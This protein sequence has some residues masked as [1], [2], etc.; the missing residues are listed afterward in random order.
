LVGTSSQPGNGFPSGH[1]F[2]REN[3]PAIARVKSP[4]KPSAVNASAAG[5]AFDTVGEI[6]ELFESQLFSG[7]QSII[8]AYEKNFARRRRVVAPRHF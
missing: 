8:P 6:R 7:T 2:H 5:F 1:K 3:P 4:N